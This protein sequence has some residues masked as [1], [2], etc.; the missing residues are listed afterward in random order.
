MGPDAIPRHESCQDNTSHYLNSWD[1]SADR[2]RRHGDAPGTD[3]TPLE[4]RA[5]NGSRPYSQAEHLVRARDWVLELAPGASLELRFAALTHD[6]ERHFP[7]GPQQD[8]AADEWDDPDYLFAHSTRSA[9]IVQEWLEDAPEAP[10]ESFIRGVRRLILLH[11][12]GGDARRRPAAGGRLAVVPRDA[13]GAGR[14]LGDRRP[15]LRPRRRTRSCATC[16]TGSGS[17]VRA[18]SPTRLY[19][20]AADRLR[21]AGISG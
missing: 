17:R 20:E 10:D 14:R 16:A 18:R 12:L 15:L 19:A 13:A 2:M 9:D 1:V 21:K 4:A 8:F 5:S 6:I 3:T 7:G 11:E